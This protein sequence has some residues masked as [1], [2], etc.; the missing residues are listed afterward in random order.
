M[1]SY[2]HLIV[3]L[4]SLTAV[5]S[6]LTFVVLFFLLYKRKKKNTNLTIST[7][8]NNNLDLDYFFSSLDKLDFGFYCYF[9][10]SKKEYCSNQLATF[11]D[12]K[13]GKDST[14]IE[15]ISKFTADDGEQLLANINSLINYGKTFELIVNKEDLKTTSQKISYIITGNKIFLEDVD[16]SIVVVS[17][18]HFNAL[19]NM[20]TNIGS[21]KQQDEFVKNLPLTAWLFDNNLNIMYTNYYTDS[22]SD[23]IK[24]HMK[25]VISNKKHFAT[26]LILEDET[27]EL[28]ITPLADNKF[29]AYIVNT[30]SK[31]EAFSTHNIY[32][33][34][35]QK[36]PLPYMLLDEKLSIISCSDEIKKIFKIESYNILSSLSYEEFLRKLIRSDIINYEQKEISEY[37]ETE[38][39]YYENNNSVFD[40]KLELKSRKTFNIKSIPIDEKWLLVFNDITEKSEQ[41]RK[42]QDLANLQKITLNKLN[43]AV[44]FVSSD[45]R[46]GLF[47]KKFCEIWNID[48]SFLKTNPHLNDIFKLMGKFTTNF[49]EEQ[50]ISLSDKILSVSYPKNEE[51]EFE[52]KS[53]KIINFFYSNLQGGGSLLIFNDITSIKEVESS[54]QYKADIAEKAKEQ[55]VSYIN[56][57]TYEIRNPLHTINLNVDSLNKED[58]DHLNKKH[59]SY[60]QS[61]SNASLQLSDIIARVTE[62]AFLYAERK[63]INFSSFN[64]NN[65]IE[66]IITSFKYSNS[67]V[68]IFYK[69]EEVI[70]LVSDDGI[71]RNMLEHTLYYLN[72]IQQGDTDITIVT[73]Q[74][75]GILSIK[76][77]SNVVIH[78]SDINFLKENN[79][80]AMFSGIV[81]LERYVRAL[82]G[83]LTVSRDVVNNSI[84]TYELKSKIS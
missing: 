13:N 48:S 28:D 44:M 81:L 73:K 37:L 15:F 19:Q 49:K 35:K 34:I 43:E 61:I 7:N 1:N 4:L 25:Y 5:F 32:N 2:Y 80:Q 26:E 36:L 18:R 40:K 30:T 9:C 24:K 74:K 31:N 57:A 64:L 79:E 51:V 69:Q 46:V 59:K 82:H 62:L 38:L 42:F 22:L 10:S 63:K 55:V 78:E 72:S 66:S 58:K 76:F 68:R 54:L 14:K 17:V 21:H 39:K 50:Y 53:K 3:F 56:G 47:N 71:V 60:I 29:F 65:L 11:L 6:F 16:E 84:L 12:L 27:F 45:G 8:I 77:I 67:D 52:L 83:G 33:I 75:L 41:E 70:D 20:V 23:D